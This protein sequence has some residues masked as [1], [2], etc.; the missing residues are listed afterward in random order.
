MYGTKIV[1]LAVTICCNV[2][3][4]S[5]ALKHTRYLHGLKFAYRT[6][7]NYFLKIS[8][9]MTLRGEGVRAMTLTLA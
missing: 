4:S 6:L 8:V 9:I 5:L 3:V 1:A 2:V 7:P